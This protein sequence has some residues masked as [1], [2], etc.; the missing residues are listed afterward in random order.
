MYTDNRT[1]E[2]RLLFIK[3]LFSDLFPRDKIMTSCIQFKLDTSYKEYLK[4]IHKSYYE[5]LEKDPIK[6]LNKIDF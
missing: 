5:L 2:T 4:E 3:N 6:V 1:F